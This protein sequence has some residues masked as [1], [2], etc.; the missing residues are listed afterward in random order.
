MKKTMNR[1]AAM[2]LALVLIA[3]M[4][5]VQ[6]FAAS[7]DTCNDPNCTCNQPDLLFPVF[8]MVAA[9]NYHSVYLT[10]GG[11]VYA[12]GSEQLSQYANRGTRCDVWTWEDIVAVS[13]SSH[14]VGLKADGT[15]HAVGVNRYGQCN[16]DG[17]KNIVSVDTGNN[18]TVGL[19]ADGTVVAVGDNSYGQ[20]NVS[21][22]RNIIQVAASEETTYALTEDGRVLSAGK[23]NYGSGWNNIVSISAGPYHVVGLR[24]DGTVVQEGSCESWDQNTDSWGRI[25][26][27]SAGTC[28]TLGLRADGSVVAVGSET[29][30]K[31]QCD[32]NGW[33]DIVAI[34]AG[35]Y[36]SIGLRSDGT[37]VAVGSN[38]YDQCDIANFS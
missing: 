5:P 16:V 30:Q 21:R 9:G 24:A 8:G 18:H 34:S 33:Y 26:A 11:R 15:V 37:I 10:P 19:K 13:A 3:C 35:M 22:W 36:H 17:W 29:N 31:G 12:V 28:H 7:C 6:S 20:C 23:K 2:A 38:G 25:V 4:L 1:F 14:T 32:V 27:I